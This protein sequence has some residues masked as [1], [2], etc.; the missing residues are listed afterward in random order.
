MR[1]RLTVAVLA[2][3][4]LWRQPRA[5]EEDAVSLREWEWCRAAANPRFL[6]AGCHNTGAM[7][8]TVPGTVLT[9]LL[10]TEVAGVDGDSVYFEDN[11]RRIPDM[12]SVGR[13]FFT[14][15]FF[16]EIQLAAGVDDGAP[17]AYFLEFKGVNY[18]A[19]V[20]LDEELIGV[21]ASAF[22]HHWILLPADAAAARRHRLAVLVS[23]VDHAGEADGGQGGDHVIARN[24]AAPQMVCGWDTLQGTPDRGTGIFDEVV[25]HR[26]AGLQLRFPH[27]QTRALRFSGGATL[28]AEEGARS[29]MGAAAF[30]ERHGSLSRGDARA[31]SAVVQFG[32]VVANAL[33]FDVTVRMSVE[34]LG[35]RF[36]REATV[37]AGETV[38]VAGWTETLH[39]ADG[40]GL[41]LWFPH[42][43]G[44]PALHTARFCLSSAHPLFQGRGCVSTAERRFG[45]RVV[46]A[47]VAPGGRGFGFAVNG[48]RVFLAGGNWIATDQLS[49][50]AASAER[51]DA[52]L[53]MHRWMGM[54]A[55]RV[56]GGGTAERDGFY[57]A[58]DRHGI[59]VLQD[60]WM[61]GDNNGRWAGNASWPDDHALYLRAV[62]DTFVRLRGSASLLLYA[63]GNE[64]FPAEES[65][66]PDIAAGIAELLRQRDA[67]RFYI[68]STMAPGR[69]GSAAPWDAEYALAPIDGP[70]GMLRVSDFWAPQPGLEPRF[71]RL[72]VPLQPEVGSASQPTIRS[73]RRFLGAGALAAFP[74]R[75]GAGAGEAWRYH[76]FLPL[77]TGAYDH[78]YAYEGG[79]GGAPPSAAWYAMASQ[80]AQRQQYQALFEGF[81]SGM[82]RSRTGV[83]VWKSQAPWPTLRGALYDYYLA[84]T[85]GFYG[86][87]AA[88]KNEIHAQ[89]RWAPDGRLSWGVDVVSRAAVDVEGAVLRATWW[90]LEG[91][92]VHEEPDVVLRSVEADAVTAAVEAL[93]WPCG[94]PRDG[95]LLLG[96]ALETGGGAPLSSNE[97]WIGASPTPDE[98]DY[99]AVAALRPVE[100]TAERV[101][102]CAPGAP[103]S[104]TYCFALAVP[105]EAPNVAFG[106]AAELLCGAG[107]GADDRVL[108]ALFSD[109][110]FFVRPG[111]VRNLTVTLRRVPTCP[112][113]RLAVEGWNVAPSSLPLAPAGYL[114]SGDSLA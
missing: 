53:S 62:N 69:E 41:A 27:V 73:L 104:F 54:N 114:G 101:M 95:V 1:T 68:P 61:T 82:W 108:P 83:L 3:C 77:V 30:A 87:R 33:P 59:L 43:H 42:T 5:A 86:A 81:S 22:A 36:S 4:F 7:A 66:P 15:F 102:D 67:L 78:V 29:G 84:P 24:A 9:T 107:G 72:A 28:T 10:A 94:A 99:A 56:W 105:G 98:P 90:S 51:Y 106:V 37:P 76:N 34:A 112:G 96:L 85:G 97:Y 31:L 74:R 113:L 25:L 55:V 23:P 14:L 13:E 91:R 58:A 70:Y 89:L 48:R 71:Q 80:L 111:T 21:T 19:E 47:F 100:V 11:L 6:A 92:A 8:A 46:S 45:L 35:Q 2:G 103:G 64:L 39:A 79:G 52:E 60:L 50:F 16:T 40:G 110:Y 17:R 93:A 26:T 88:L 18:R 49:R 38:D 20:Y 75:G 44:E 65:P 12:A 63:G 32:A 57:A 109:G